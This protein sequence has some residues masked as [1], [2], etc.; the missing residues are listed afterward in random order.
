MPRFCFQ[1]PARDTE[2]FC[3]IK[4]PSL[5]PILKPDVIDGHQSNLSS[6][7]SAASASAASALWPV[8]AYS[9][10]AWLRV[11]R[12]DAGY[13]LVVID[14]HTRQSG[15]GRA[16]VNRGVAVWIDASKRSVVLSC[17][18]DMVVFS[19]VQILPCKWYHLVVTHTRAKEVTTAV[20]C[21]STALCVSLSVC[22][23]LSL[24]LFALKCL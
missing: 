11:D 9:V 7:S 18:K 5:Y 15:V 14:V 6:S 22:L 16:A 4:V 21:R 2:A 1:P 8:Q 10:S 13:R 23:S 19:G 17:D 3:R 24:S 20:R 12:Y